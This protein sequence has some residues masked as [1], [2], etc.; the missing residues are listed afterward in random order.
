M[1]AGSAFI[2]VFLMGIADNVNR[3]TNPKPEKTRKAANA[4]IMHVPGEVPFIKLMKAISMAA[5]DP[6]MVGSWGVIVVTTRFLL[7]K[8]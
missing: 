4:F 6:S 3:S 2:L 8:H 5:Q 1:R 7:T